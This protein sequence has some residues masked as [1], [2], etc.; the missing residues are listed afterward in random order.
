MI[1]FSD[2]HDI[3]LNPDNPKDEDEKA[4]ISSLIE[5]RD[6][7]TD[8]YFRKKVKESWK[9]QSV[10]FHGMVPVEGQGTCGEEVFK[11]SYSGLINST[12]G[13]QVH[14]S[15]EDYSDFISKMVKF[16]KFATKTLDV[17]TEKLDSI[18]F[19][20]LDG[21][22]VDFE[23]DQDNSQVIVREVPQFSGEDQVIEVFFKI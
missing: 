14:C 18:E 16:S 5:R 1:F 23:V 17:D 20:E 12:G 13:V 15:S 9:V 11:Y 10:K 2:T 6:S 22:S 8:K 7:Y 21:Q 3:G 19:V 4:A